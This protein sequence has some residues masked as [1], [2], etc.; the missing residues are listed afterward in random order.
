VVTLPRV[1][2]G[3]ELSAKELYSL[4]CLRV[5]IFVV[6][7]HIAYPD[8][9]GLDLTP[10]T[11]HFWVEDGGE[12]LSCL[13]VAKEGNQRRIQ[14]VCTKREYRRKGL[15]RVLFNAA[16][17]TF[18]DQTLL[19]DAQP[20]IVDF[21]RQFGFVVSGPVFLDFGASLTPMRRDSNQSM[22]IMP[23]SL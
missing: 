21:Y 13:R 2:G 17:A 7:H 10:S 19:L 14:R 3:S 23:P 18:S 11:H 9:D 16:V 8:L 4:L 20:Y 1:R 22:P 15:A 5:R 12:V 6:E